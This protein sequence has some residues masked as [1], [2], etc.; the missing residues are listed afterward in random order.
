MSDPGVTAG[1]RPAIVIDLARAG[2][3]DAVEVGRGGFGVVFRCTQEALNRTVAVKLL[4]TD[5]DTVSRERF[6]RE[7]RAMGGLSGHPNVVDVLQVGVTH[8]GRPY[9]VMPFQSLD[10]LAVRVRREGPIPWEEAARLG[11]RL[12]GALESAHRVGTLHRDVKPANILL[13][14]YGEAQITDFGIARIEGGFET[15]TGAFTGS[16]SYSAPEVLN[17]RPPTPASDIYG[18]AAALF[19]VIA[20]R[21]AFE[22]R[23]GEEIIAQFLRITGQPIPD[24]RGHGI[25]DDLCAVLENAMAKDPAARPASAEAFGRQLQQVQRDA[26]L[27]VAEMALPVARRQSDHDIS[28]SGQGPDDDRS[29]RRTSNPLPLVERPWAGTY[30]AG[31][32]GSMPTSQVP[33]SQVPPSPVP[34]SPSGDHPRF[35]AAANANNTANTAANTTAHNPTNNTAATAALSSAP[36]DGATVVVGAGGRPGSAPNGGWPS[37]PAQRSGQ[38]SQGYG[39]HTSGASQTVIHSGRPGGPP[40]PPPRA[41]GHTGGGQFGPPS[42]PPPLP[43][44]T[45]GNPRRR[46]VLVAAVVTVVVLLASLVVVGVLVL[47]NPGDTTTA[48]APP[49]TPVVPASAW[50]E[51]RADPT[52][53]QQVATTV[54]DGTVW[55]LGGITNGTATPLME[56]YDPAI[57]TWKT[58]IAL[59]VPLSHEMAVTYRGEIVVL[60]GWVA[61]GGNLTAVSSNKVFVQRGGGW[62]ELPPMLS[63]HVAGGA[64]VVGDQIIVSGG[65]ADGKLVPTTEVFDGK[66]W[67]KVADLPTPREHLAMATDGTYAYVVGGR[68]LASDKNSAALERY[69]PKAD[70]WAGLAP[71]PAPRGGVGAAVSDGRL[72]VAGGEE[73]TSV[74]ATVFAYDIASNTWSD[75]PNLP[76]GRHG[77]AVAA[78]DKTV[79]AIGGATQP[80]HTASTGVGEALQTP[81]RR[82]QA[83][84]VWRELKAAPLARQFAGSTVAGGKLWIAGGLTQDAASAAVYGY[85]PVIDNWTQGPDLPIQLHHLAAVTYHNEIVVIG[86]WSPANGNLSGLVSG[87]VFALRNGAWVELPP[88][89]HPRV[90]EGAAVVGDKIVVFGGQANNQLVPTTEVF[91][92]TRWTDAAPIPTPREHMTAASD[93]TYAY[94]VGG[95]NLS[96]D[97]NSAAF[98]RFDPAT[99]AW[100]TMPNMPTPRGGVAATCIDGRI[101]AA[102]GEEPTRVLNTVEA[103][104]ID[105]GTWS[106]LP[107]LPVARHGMALATVGNSVY[108]VGGAQRPTHQQSATTVEA[109]DFS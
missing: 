26:G 63:P 81:P 9:I 45:P 18:L 65:Q 103:Y 44:P 27:P 76:A 57:D 77:M 61:Q 55:V 36:P 56:G 67:R 38:G 15:A 5:L 47:R 91:D 53:R 13:S 11:V 94:A 40:V 84:P 3:T 89:T 74:D 99:G 70:S 16:L 21:A 72:V 29:P 41:E 54:A 62:T 92:G 28:R 33:T 90:A 59:P 93:G 66:A 106:A 37:P 60:G 48:A 50:R 109:L 82:L 78:V 23:E 85:D 2:F 25:P 51:L 1:G 34:H 71:M 14:D 98:E 6:F 100:Q 68:D 52:P 17:G 42:D 22:R 87:R 4:H 80:S 83:A 46:F 43:T 64:V 32:P 75:L 19:S 108:A 24:L 7:G 104:D 31:A 73:P 10:S 49:V 88:L 97:K 79:Y 69:D 86:G 35:G 12:A 20:G 107:P 102:G 58:G 101:V 96:S 30:G 39:D 95:R 105:T 8:S